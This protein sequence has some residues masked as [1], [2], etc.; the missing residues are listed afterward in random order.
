MDR[1]RKFFGLPAPE[2]L[3]LVRA[4]TLLA[5]VRIA[6]WLLPFKVLR[7]MLSKLAQAHTRYPSECHFPSERGVW[8][9][10]AASRYVPRATCLT[11]A[12]AGQ[13]LL[14]FNGTS[15]SVRIGVAK[16]RTRDLEAHAWLESQGTI[17]IGGADADQRYACL[18]AFN[19]W[20]R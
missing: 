3:L 12:L 13:V 1:L 19:P 8:A 14:G 10:Q 2:R 9:L 18:L 20:E 17:L 6:L 4:F 16:R 15:T 7:W 11:Q 5:A